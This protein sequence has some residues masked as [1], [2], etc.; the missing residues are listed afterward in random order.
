MRSL[1]RYREVGAAVV[2]DKAL[3]ARWPDYRPNLDRVL[4]GTFEQAVAD[5]ATVFELDI[6]QLDWQ[7]GEAEARRITQSALVVLG[8]ESPALH[9]RFSETYQLLLDWLPDA[10]GFVLPGVTHFLQ[11]ENPRGMAEA[12]AAFYARHPIPAPI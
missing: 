12:L 4:P 6:G 1:Q 3:R 9:P 10:E 7:F 8:G 2:V 11:V 5:A